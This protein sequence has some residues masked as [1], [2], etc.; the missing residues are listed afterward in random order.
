M[1][2]RGCTLSISTMRPH[3]NHVQRNAQ[4]TGW[5]ANA[6]LAVLEASPTQ[7]ALVDRHGIVVQVNPA[8]VR[9]AAE[10]GGDPQRTGVSQDYLAACRLAGREG[11]D[12]YHALKAVLD[13]VADMQTVEYPCHTPTERRW[14]RMRCIRVDAPPVAAAVIHDDLTDHYLAAEA[15]RRLAT[16]VTRVQTL[17]DDEARTTRALNTI[18]HKLRTPLTPVRLQIATLARQDLPPKLAGIV[19]KMKES[20]ERLVAAVDETVSAIE[21]QQAPLKAEHMDSGEAGARLHALL[22]QENVLNNVSWHLQAGHDV[23]VDLALLAPPVAELLRSAKALD[24]EG[25]A[26][27]YV[28]FQDGM[29]LTIRHHDA[30]PEDHPDDGGRGLAIYMCRTVARIHGGTFDVTSHNGEGSYVFDLPATQPHQA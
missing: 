29:Q 12:A 21:L 23:D 10:N 13:G 2:E 6:A 25:H 26:E 3:A 7:T 9:F 16:E 8:W 20:T 24:P 14:F 11:G 28:T 22:Q 4:D 17:V 15:R 30:V 5:Q 27:V 1:G 19:A 18:G